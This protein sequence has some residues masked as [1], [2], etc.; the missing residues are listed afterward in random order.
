MRLLWINANQFETLKHF[1]RCEVHGVDI[2]HPVGIP[3]WPSFQAC[4]N[5]QLIAKDE[6]FYVLTDLGR[7]ALN[8]FPNPVSLEINYEDHQR[9]L[10]L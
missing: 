2:T 1:E 8:A 4:F 3:T 9:S 7:E 5:K 6:G 10:A